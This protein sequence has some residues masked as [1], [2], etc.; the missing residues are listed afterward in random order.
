VIG[1]LI[2][3]KALK[4]SD[5]SNE[6]N[7]QKI[8]GTR[9]NR[10]MF[11]DNDSGSGSVGIG[12]SVFNGA[13][14]AKGL[15]EMVDKDNKTIA[16][17]NAIDEILIQTNGEEVSLSMKKDGSLTVKGKNVTFDITDTFLVKAKDVDIQ[18]TG[19]I[20]GQWRYR[21]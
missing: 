17:L 6:K 20:K 18:A 10:I 15:F 21:S 3:G 4:T 12:I 2:N 16:K 7:T 14:T 9:D 5:D 19:N 8:I 11:I 1:A 13:D